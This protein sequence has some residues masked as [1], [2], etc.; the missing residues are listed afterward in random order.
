MPGPPAARVGDMTA[1]GSPLAPGPGSMNV[2]IGSQPAWRGITAA[3]AAALAEAVAQGA[4]NIAKATAEQTAAAGT[5]GAPAAATNLAKTVADTAANL[6]SLMASF[7]A[8]IHAC[9]VVK[10][11]PDGIGVV[12]NGSQTVLINSLAACRIGDIIQEASS[13]NSIAQGLPTVLIGG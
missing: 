5:P 10:P 11:I 12:I 2:L 13:V 3:Q 9:P 4:E 7:A 1:H 8:D 6:T